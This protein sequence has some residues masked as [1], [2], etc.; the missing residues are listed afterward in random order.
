MK[1][2]VLLI[3]AVFIC[4]ESFCQHDKTEANEIKRNEEYIY[5]EHSDEEKAFEMLMN[6]IRMYENFEFEIDS[7]VSNVRTKAQSFK[8]AKNSHSVVTLYYIHKKDLLVTEGDVC[9]N[10]IVGGIDTVIIKYILNLD[11]YADLNTYLEK[12]KSENH[13]IQY[14]LLRGDDGTRNCY[15]IIFDNQRKI[16]AVLDKTLSKDLLSGKTVDFQDYINYP[17]IWLQT[18]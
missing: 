13:D 5:A 12:R 16:I 10:Q 11:G 3:I 17:K 14:K 18:F 7:S 15:W 4:G 9:E 6:K 1:Q 2:I 8:Y